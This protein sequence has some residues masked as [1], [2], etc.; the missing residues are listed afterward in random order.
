MLAKLV[1]TLSEEFGV[2]IEPSRLA[3]YLACVLPRSESSTR[4]EHAL[5]ELDDRSWQ[6]MI[7]AARGEN[8]VTLLDHRLEMLPAIPNFV[9]DTL[10]SESTSL[11]A[12]NR[13]Y[14]LATAELTAYLSKSGIRCVALKGATLSKQLYGDERLRDVRD[15]D[16]LIHPKDAYATAGLLKEKGYVPDV[17]L[18][19]LEHSSFM[20]VHRQV[21]FKALRGAL[22][23]DLH[24]ML[25]NPWIM[26]ELN[27]ADLI[28]SSEGCSVYT[29]TTPAVNGK[30]LER[31]LRANLSNSHAIEMRAL[32]DWTTYRIVTKHKTSAQ[33]LRDFVR[34]HVIDAAKTARCRPSD[35]IKETMRA[36]STAPSALQAW[37][38]HVLRLRTR[39][40][41]WSLVA[42][43]RYQLSSWS[44]P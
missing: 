24:W 18:S 39:F 2:E 38:R 28:A 7:E 42:R 5:S 31:V 12:W 3:L 40:E 34:S 26:P 22:E 33:P 20:K 23:V 14:A 1:E 10:K 43:A 36:P 13:I 15:I 37:L 25:T 9:R 11:A 21:S 30:N 17:P 29:L 16:I 35:V 6:G 8:L 27:G 19:Q 44:Y 32:V 41:L 4:L